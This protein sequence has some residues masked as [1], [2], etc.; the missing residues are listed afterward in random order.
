MFQNTY[1][2]RKVL[3]TGNTGFKGSWLSAWLLELGAKVYGLSVDIPSKPSLFEILKLGSR[4]QHTMADLR[5]FST[6]LELIDSIKPDFIFHLAAQSI[7]SKS[8]KDP[9]YTLTT[10]TIGTA[11]I[12]EAVRRVNHPCNLVLITSDKCYE[13][14]EQLEGYHETDRLGGKDLYSASKAAAEIVIR[15]YFQSFFKDCK[16]EIRLCSVRAGNIIGGGDWSDNRLIPDC[17][18]AWV[19][20]KPVE[21]R[22]PQAVR[23]WQHVLEPLNAY[24]TIGHLLSK[25]SAINGNAYNLGPFGNSVH[26]VKDLIGSLWNSWQDNLQFEAFDLRNSLKFPE[27][28]LLILDSSKAEKD[29]GWRTVL[30]MTQ[31]SKMT[32]EWYRGFYDD[33]ISMNDFTLKQIE[34]YKQVLNNNS[35]E[36]K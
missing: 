36:A 2:G 31:T 14:V 11:H 16:T 33:K 18:R 32:A 12:L 1:Y 15:A 3:I 35:I 28:T 21:I 30:D 9:L 19:D 17:I 25:G 20:E 6:V 27:A 4:S 7:I 26:S 8:F 24:L 22:N 23:P 34:Y 10:N 5:D 13:N 29:L